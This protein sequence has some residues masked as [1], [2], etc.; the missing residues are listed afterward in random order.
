MYS[1]CSMSLYSVTGIILIVQLHLG[2]DT[3]YSR[4]K[5]SYAIIFR[6]IFS[7]FK[8]LFANELVHCE[9]FGENVEQETENSF[10]GMD[11]ASVEQKQN[12]CP[13]HTKSRT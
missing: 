12:I 9:A 5:I 1:L 6:I 8:M 4:I 13:G 2:L 10:K 3:F 11:F 7:T